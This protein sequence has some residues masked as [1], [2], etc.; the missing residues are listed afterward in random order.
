VDEVTQLAGQAGAGLVVLSSA[1]TEA[2]KQAEHA[3]Q[4]LTA[5]RP[6]LNVLTGRPG[7]RLS[8]LLVRAASQPAASGSKHT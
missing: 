3:R 5:A 6:G 2:V 4:A 7:D 8:D 1:T